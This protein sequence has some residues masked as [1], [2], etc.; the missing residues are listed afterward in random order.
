MQTPII[1]G[2]FSKDWPL[3]IAAIHDFEE[4][5]YPKNTAPWEPFPQKKNHAL[6]VYS[7]KAIAHSGEGVLSLTVDFQAHKVDPDTE[8][9]GV[10][11]TSEQFQKVKAVGGWIFIPKSAHVRNNRFTTHIMAWVYAQDGAPIGFYSEDKDVVPGEWA[12]LFLGVLHTNDSQNASFTWDG[13]IDELYITVWS[14]HAYSGPIYFDDIT[15]YTD[16]KVIK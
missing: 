16:A 12:P 10:G 11:I 4:I 1:T 5:Q 3:E 8:Y 9:G 13:T 6:E 7:E 14:D 15:I 2:Q